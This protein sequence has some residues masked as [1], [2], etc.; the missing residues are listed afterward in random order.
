MSR[1][2]QKRNTRYVILGLREV[3]ML[4]FVGAVCFLRDGTFRQARSIIQA[5]YEWKI[6]G[7]AKNILRPLQKFRLHAGI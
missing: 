1:A 4:H 2:Q 3:V 6:P 5:V 7:D